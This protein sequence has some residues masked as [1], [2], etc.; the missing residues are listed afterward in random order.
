MVRGTKY[1]KR[2][3]SGQLNL[4]QLAPLELAGHKKYPS[5]I[6][7]PVTLETEPS[8]LDSL[9]P[10]MWIQGLTLSLREP[11]VGTFKCFTASGLV[12]IAR[13][14]GRDRILLPETVKLADR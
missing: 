9:K 10:G 7:L 2:E 5:R 3:E 4:L 6:Q 14:Q 1:D 8:I 12:L 13:S 11:E